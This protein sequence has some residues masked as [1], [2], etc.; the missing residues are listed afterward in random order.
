[1]RQDV[2]QYVSSE[3]MTLLEHLTPRA[4]RNSLKGAYRSVAK[5][6]RSSGRSSL[7]ASSLSVQGNRSDWS[8][9]VRTRV[10]SRGG[11]FMLTVKGV[12]GQSMHTN[13]FGRQKPILMWAEDG[14]RERRTRGG[15][16][17]SHSTGRM[18][19]YGYISR[20][21]GSL[22]TYVDGALGAELERCVGVQA[23]KLGW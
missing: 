6:V 23:A 16:R 4:V 8:R 1:M 13:R 7:S 22:Y 12:K 17:R 14:T 2:A 15:L 3:V 11:G 10:Y 20:I 21:E 18:P 9:G 5:Y 19:R